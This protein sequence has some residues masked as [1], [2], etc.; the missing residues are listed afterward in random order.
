MHF[1]REHPEHR[2][3]EPYQPRATPWGSVTNKD[4]ALKGRHTVGT[5]FQGFVHRGRFSQGVALGW[6]DAGPLALGTGAF[7]VHDRL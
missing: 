7:K 2:R 5:P 6:Y 1:C 3:C 4:K